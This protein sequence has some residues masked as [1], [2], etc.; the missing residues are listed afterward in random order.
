MPS[1]FSYFDNIN[2]SHTI[3]RTTIKNNIVF[4]L[5]NKATMH[6]ICFVIP[7]FARY[8]EKNITYSLGAM[9]N[10]A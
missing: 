6:I 1:T 3:Y 10:T 4:S 2:S 5:Y 9:F 8:I 7:E